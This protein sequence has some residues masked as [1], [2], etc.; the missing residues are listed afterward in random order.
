MHPVDKMSVKEPEPGD[1]EFN[2]YLAYVSFGVFF[3]VALNGLTSRF[4]VPESASNNPRQR[5]KWANIFTSLVHSTITGLGA[6]LLFYYEPDALDDMINGFSDAMHV[7][8][9]FSIGYFVYDFLDMALYNPK[10][11]TYELL[12]HHFC[13]IVCFGIAARTRLYL[14]YAVLALVIEINSI[15]LHLRQ[16]LIIQGASKQRPLYKHVAVLNVA[17][18][19]PFRVFLLGWMI[20]WLWYNRD[21]L[22]LVYFTAGIVGL[23]VIMAMNAILFYRILSVDLFNKNGRNEGGLKVAV[24]QKQNGFHAVSK[25]VNG[26]IDEFFNGDGKEKVE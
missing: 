19:V 24:K 13:V 4:L 10:K 21:H 20:R 1:P 23:T 6:P 11:S 22:P 7:L 3:F 8:V 26:V 15:F 17:T 12:F 9:A 14:P 5:W 18:F 25:D 2:H 16:L